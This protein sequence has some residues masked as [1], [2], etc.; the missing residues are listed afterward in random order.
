MIGM[1]TTSGVYERFIET[2]KRTL[3]ICS[4]LERDD[5]MVQATEETSPPK[6]HLAHTTWFFE[7]FALKK[8]LKGYKEFDSKFSELFN[9]YYNSIGEFLPKP[10]RML[11]SRPSLEMILQYRHYVESQIEAILHG[12]NDTKLQELKDIVLLGINHEEQH[13][14]LLVMDIKEN[15]FRSPFRPR[16]GS[17]HRK[18]TKARKLEWIAFEGGISEIGA[19][20]TG[21]SFDN[22]LPRHKVY[23]YP[24]RIASRIVTNG[25]FLEFI[26]DGGYDNP[27]NWLSEGW[28]LI[29]NER[30]KMPHYWEKHG[31]DYYCFTPAGMKKLNPDEPVCHVSYYEADAYA[32][33][34]GCRLPTEEEWENAFSS[35]K[36][37]PKRKEYTLH[38]SVQ[39]SSDKFQ[40]PGECWEWTSSAYLPYPGF[41]PLKGPLG[42]YNG[43]FMSQQ[44]TLRGDSA[45]T[46][47]GHSRITY[48]NFYH[49][50]SRWQFA[51]IRLCRGPGHD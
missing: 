22:E 15:M 29:R 5:Y 42:E 11:L 28:A 40:G 43:K 20:D 41:K 10:N 17:M 21:F 34:S 9:S 33:W 46:P 44:M 49:P 7:T 18:T 2:R 38:P 26:M 14:E 37:S 4:V 27:A 8:Y 51:G 36:S 23:L 12:T 47:P 50:E 48:R 31:D 35:R 45:A 13:Q 16:F 6:W 25:E 30:W 3:E 24:Y 32:R 19:T 1:K 39:A